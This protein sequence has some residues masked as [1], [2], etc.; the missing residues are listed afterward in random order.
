M[1]RAAASFP[2]LDTRAASPVQVDGTSTGFLTRKP[3][4]K[5]SGRETGPDPTHPP[6]AS[7]STCPWWLSQ[8]HP[9]H[10]V[11]QAP[12]ADQ[13]SA[14]AEESNASPSRGSQGCVLRGVE[15]TFSLFIT[16]K[17]RPASFTL[18]LA[19]E[20]R[21]PHGGARPGL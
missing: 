11:Q 10:S 14:A 6:S 7:L 15:A 2:L 19:L 17:R 16:G 3:M 13:D 21:N 4:E 5:P 12:P 8:G 18:M 1:G 20:L 9:T